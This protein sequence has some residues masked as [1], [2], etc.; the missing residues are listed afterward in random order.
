MIILSCEFNE[1]FEYKKSTLLL[2]TQKKWFENWYTGSSNTQ[3]LLNHK[4]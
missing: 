4:L 1:Q 2:V 3:S